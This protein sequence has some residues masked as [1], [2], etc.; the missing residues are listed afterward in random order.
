MEDDLISVSSRERVCAEVYESAARV[1][2]ACPGLHAGV[3]WL[4]SRGAGAK[5]AS[6]CVFASRI[7]GWE[8]ISLNWE[9]SLSSPVQVCPA[10]NYL[11]R[12]LSACLRRRRLIVS[13]VQSSFDDRFAT[14]AEIAQTLLSPQFQPLGE[15]RVLHAA[16]N[17]LA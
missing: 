7:G 14:C 8:R 5:P 10:G 4:R 13:C 2:V 17:E 16:L 6:T 11:C 1:S 15:C 9:R 12:P 3:M